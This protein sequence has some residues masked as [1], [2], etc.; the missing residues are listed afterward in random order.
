[1]GPHTCPTAVSARMTAKSYIRACGN[2]HAPPRSATNAAL[3][4]KLKCWGMNLSGALGL[5][6][7]DFRGDQPGEMGAVLSHVDLG[8]G[9]VAVAVEAADLRACAILQGGSLKCWGNNHNGV[10]GS[11]TITTT[12]TSPARWATRSRR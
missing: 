7:V 10:L 8:A 4:G 1:M 12:A 2:C 3:D 9:K 6:D 5:G 11:A